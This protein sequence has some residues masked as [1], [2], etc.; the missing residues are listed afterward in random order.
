M[1]SRIGHP[2]RHHAREGRAQTR[3]AQHGAS[4]AFLRLGRIALRAHCIHAGGG[5][6][7]PPRH[8]IHLLRADAFLRLQLL[9][10]SQR[11]GGECGLRLRCGL[12][13]LSCLDSGLRLLRRGAQSRSVECNQRLP[14][15]TLS[16]SRTKTCSM[17]PITCAEIVA[18]SRAR[19]VPVARRVKGASC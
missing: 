3:I 12:L 16:P 17:R 5:C 8:L 4:A 19:R 10:T 15:R 1:R 14:A 6:F 11:A 18:D 2:R 7:G 13:A 9:V